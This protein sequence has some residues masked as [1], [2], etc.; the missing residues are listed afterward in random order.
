MI[1]KLLAKYLFTA[2]E[3]YVNEHWDEIV[4]KGKDYAL[5]VIATLKA[6]LLG[7]ESLFAAGDASLSNFA[8]ACDEAIAKAEAD[9]EGGS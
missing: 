1:K 7:E 9:S 8:A 6:K 2:L 3:S 4:A 5:Q